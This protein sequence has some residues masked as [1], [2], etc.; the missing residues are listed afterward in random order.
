MLNAQEDERIPR[1]SVDA[2]WDAARDPKELHWLPGR[3]MQ[4]DRPETLE[5]LVEKMLA[6]AAGRDTADVP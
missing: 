1:E 4:G 5:Q 3:H 2:L 6:I